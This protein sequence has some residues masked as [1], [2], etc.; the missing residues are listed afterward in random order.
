MKKLL[1]TLSCALFNLT[2]FSAVPLT[3]EQQLGE[4]LFKDKNLSFNHNQSCETC[5]S[6]SP[7]PSLKGVQGIVPGFADPSNV[8]GISPISVGSIPR[9]TGTLNAPTIAYASYSPEFGWDEDEQ[10][11]VGG[12]FWNGRATN[13]VEQAKKPFLNPV[14]MAMLDELD[15]VNRIKANP[16]YIRD[17]QK[18][19]QLN[20]S[21]T[22]S[23]KAIQDTYTA[24]AKA[25]SA[26][27]QS[28]T[29][30]KFNSK[31]DYYIAGTA[32]LS[33][34]E[35]KG[36]D[37]FQGKAGCSGCHKM[38][39]TVDSNGNN[40]P[41]LFTYF[42]YDNIGLPRNMA[43]PGNPVAD[44]GLGAKEGIPATEIG[45]H[46][47]KS[48][49]NIDLTPPYGH[50]GI[51]KTLD[52]IVH[53]YNTRDVLKKVKDN[54]SPEFAKTA[55]APPEIA[56]NMNTTQI[57]NL[58]LSTVEEKAIVAFL[59][60]LTDDYPLWGNNPAVV[61]TKEAR[62]PGNSP[63]PIISTKNTPVLKT[64]VRIQN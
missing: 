49:R 18:I 56:S 31:F 42:G 23:D 44:L 13:L 35:K 52:D 5:H 46:K 10:I 20:I 11:Y 55:W 6:L 37:L 3:P 63:P 28:G 48:L 53:F 60:T 58:G 15:V 59:K 33:A 16:K 45:K 43:I 14:E 39:V 24:L 62:V 47:V 25:I 54:N 8:K 26:F 34:N 12:Q 27:E 61:D 17:F 22:T 64:P 30:N 9:T 36:L 29:F 57:G 41:P 4:A 51:F 21:D 40:I 50:N 1:V 32:Q 19:Y 7:I 2:A 38:D